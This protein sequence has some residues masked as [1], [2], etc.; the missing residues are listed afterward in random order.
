MKKRWTSLVLAL[1]LALSMA[2]PAL[3]AQASMDNFTDRYTYTSGQFTD[4]PAGAWYES[5]MKD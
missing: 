1:A 5:A 2:V 4:V 3:A